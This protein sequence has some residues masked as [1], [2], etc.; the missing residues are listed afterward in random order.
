MALHVGQN[1][2]LRGSLSSR[3]NNRY[4]LTDPDALSVIITR[5]DASVI[6]YTLGVD[7]ELVRLSVG[8]YEV[9]ESLDQSGTW[10]VRWQTA[11]FRRTFTFPVAP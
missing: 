8:R 11:T 4:V 6:T 7:V 9:V 10:Q 5:P 2:L 3:V 1:A